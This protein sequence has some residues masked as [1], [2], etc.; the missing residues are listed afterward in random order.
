MLTFVDAY[1][2]HC[3]AGNVLEPL[4]GFCKPDSRMVKRRIPRN[5]FEGWNRRCQV[6]SD[7]IKASKET[8]TPLKKGVHVE[9]MDD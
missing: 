3:L 4:T 5:R 2:H 1:N 7:I 9:L 6:K 8:S